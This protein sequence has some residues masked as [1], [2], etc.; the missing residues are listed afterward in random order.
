[1]VH[2]NFI[3]KELI[4]IPIQETTAKTGD[5]TAKVMTT[6]QMIITRHTKTVAGMRPTPANV[7]VITKGIVSTTIRQETEIV[8]SL[9]SLAVV[10]TTI[11]Q[12]VAVRSGSRFEAVVIISLLRT[13]I[14]ATNMGA[15]ADRIKEDTATPTNGG[16]VGLTTTNDDES[17]IEQIAASVSKAC[18]LNSPIVNK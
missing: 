6:K 10:D 12:R 16:T 9:P 3:L 15:A 11:T 18:L 5:T 17:N 2:D 4:N 1:M 14:K 8:E 13:T 7:A